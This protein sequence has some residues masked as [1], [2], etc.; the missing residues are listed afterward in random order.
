[1]LKYKSDKRFEILLCLCMSNC[2]E[3]SDLK[4]TFYVAKIK[5][6]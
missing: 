3:F 6:L 4:N 5:V 1:M 2:R